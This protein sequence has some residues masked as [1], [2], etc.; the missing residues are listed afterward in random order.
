[1]NWIVHILWVVANYTL[2]EHKR[3]CIMKNVF[4]VLSKHSITFL[5]MAAR[6]IFIQ[7]WARDHLDKIVDELFSSKVRI[8]G[9]KSVCSDFKT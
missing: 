8:H 7:N 6:P 9:Q 1:M 5:T 3:T 2:L 4:S